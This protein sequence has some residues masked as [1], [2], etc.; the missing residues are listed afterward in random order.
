MSM[1]VRSEAVAMAQAVG[2]VHSVLMFFLEA[3]TPS[4]GIVLIF[5]VRRYSRGSRKHGN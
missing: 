3:N 2:S 5:P 1:A 4:T